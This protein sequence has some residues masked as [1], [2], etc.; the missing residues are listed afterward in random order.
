MTASQ[1][2]FTKA[3][4]SIASLSEI[5][6]P[7]N[8]EEKEFLKQNILH[9]IEGIKPK[10]LP[11]GLRTNKLN[12]LVNFIIAAILGLLLVGGTAFAAGN[13]IPGDLLYPV[14]LTAEKIALSLAL[15]Q[16]YK[17]QLQATFAE[18]RLVELQ[19]LSAKTQL[20]PAALAPPY[21]NSTPSSTPTN[22]RSAIAHETQTPETLSP[23][24]TD[25][26]KLT[27]QAR[28]NASQQ[29]SQA[30]SALRQ[31]QV[32]F[33]QKGDVQDAQNI[34]KNIS[35]LQTAAAAQNISTENSANRNTSSQQDPQ[36]GHIETN[37]ANQP[38]AENLNQQQSSG[39][40]G[41]SS[42]QNHF[43]PSIHP[44]SA[45]PQ[46]ASQTKTSSQ[47]PAAGS[48][49]SQ[50]ESQSPVQE[51]Q[52]Q[53]P[54]GEVKG[55]STSKPSSDTQ[56]DSQLPPAENYRQENSNSSSQHQNSTGHP[57]ND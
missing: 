32:S 42:S 57:N 19:K 1:K 25:L 47:N 8:Q 33:Q 12:A 53:S 7:L 23:P 51:G 3:V 36:T 48:A 31:E 50:S 40:D 15:P 27:S 52:N 56:K 41:Q 11:T 6:G 55:Q 49:P 18:Q 28:E 14:K 37:A 10:D 54:N 21:F 26:E 2:K 43:S 38:K 35:D 16:H 30:V 44:N 4:A 34:G 24:Y 17:T 13:S 5:S 39:G 29:V 22:G 45:V 9:A 20:P 46:T